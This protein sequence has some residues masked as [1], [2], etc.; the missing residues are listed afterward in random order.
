MENI[1][2]KK[3]YTLVLGNLALLVLVFYLITKYYE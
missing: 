3:W 1:N 2:W